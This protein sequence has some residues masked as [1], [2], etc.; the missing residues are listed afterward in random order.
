MNK[1][2]KPLAHEVLDAIARLLTASLPPENR[3]VFAAAAPRLIDEAIRGVLGCDS[4]RLTGWVI[5]PAERQAR[6]ER[7][8][9]AL[10][11]GEAIPDIASSELVSVSLVYKL[12]QAADLE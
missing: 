7:I 6:R 2:A 4:V 5:A 3:A 8:I 1:T 11:R 9:A 12:R 10:R